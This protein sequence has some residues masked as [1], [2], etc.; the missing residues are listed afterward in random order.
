MWYLYISSPENW[1]DKISK[2]APVT[3]CRQAHSVIWFYVH[4]VPV[5]IKVASHWM[6]FHIEGTEDGT[7]CEMHLLTYFTKL[8]ALRS[9]RSLWKDTM[10]SSSAKHSCVEVDRK[11][12]CTIHKQEHD[13]SCC[14][15]C[16]RQAPVSSG[17][18]FAGSLIL[19]VHCNS[20]HTLWQAF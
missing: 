14:A 18:S 12:N 6:Q 19:S 10:F 9:W 4:K 15:A 11:T 16:L 1:S 5:I 13:I 7:C 2:A 20:Y 17:S 3:F 8:C